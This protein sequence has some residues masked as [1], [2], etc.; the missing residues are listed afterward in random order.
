M[1][2][3]KN[4]ILIAI[5]IGFFVNAQTSTYRIEKEKINDLIHTK[6]D[7]SF[8]IPNSLLHGK[9]E[10]TL[11]PHFYNTD[12][13]TLDAK[14]M[15]IHSVKVNGIKTSYNYFENKELIIDL[16][17]SY[18][19]DEEF[20]VFIE[21]TAQPEKVIKMGL[22]DEKGLYFI[23]PTDDNP[24]IPTQIWSESEPDLASVWFPTIDSP[25]QKSTQ[26]IS[27]TVPS[28][29]VTLSN[30]NLVNQRE[31]SGGTR[32]DVW[33]QSLKHSPYLFFIGVG[34]FSIVK[35]IWNDK[36]VNYYVDKEQEP[37]AKGVFG[38]TPKMLQFFED[39]LGVQYP[40]DKYHQ[41]VVR[42][43]IS[44]AMEN[45]GAVVH[46]DQAY[47]DTRELID[48]NKWENT[49]AHEII[50]HWFGD[51]VTAESWSNL[52]L[53][54][55]FAN[56]GEYLWFEHEYG[57]DF[58][59]D[60]ISGERK[61]YLRSKQ[62]KSKDLIRFH[63]NKA[64][65]MF[66]SVTYEKGGLI[67]HMLRN[68]L[69]DE[70]FFEGLKKYLNDN[71]Y[72]TAEAHQLRIAL[73]K[74]SGK[75]L[76]WF[77]NQWFFGNGHPELLITYTIGAFENEVTINIGQT[78]NVFEF[79][80][81][82]DVY[83][84]TGKTTHTVWVNKKQESFSFSLDSKLKLI[85][86]N[87]NGTLLSEIAMNKSVQDAI[88]QYSHAKSYKSRKEAI[89]LLIENQ[90]DSRAFNSLTTALNDKSYKLRILI[91]EKLD[92]VNKYSKGKT[93]QKIEK[94]AKNDSHTLVQAAA[95]ITL[96]KL[97]DPKYK[98]HFLN[99][100]NSQSYKVIE[101]AIVGLY[102]LDKQLA[103][104]E[105][106][107][108]DDTVKSKMPK[109]LTGYYLENRVDKYMPF[110]A[111]NLIEGLFYVQDKKVADT[112]MKAF[113]WISQSDN[114]EAISNLVDSLVSNGIKYKKYGADIAALNF[115]RQMVNLQRATNNLNKK[116]LEIIIKKGM[117]EF[118]D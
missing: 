102:Q 92:L 99:A 118:I 16:G 106:D 93:I 69:G 18:S 22:A 61:S 40:W 50:H 84:E 2:L 1:I 9:A 78:N 79:P 42:E 85:D 91:L 21:Y 114:K 74:V 75:D 7:L 100:L 23:D 49:I 101:S 87:P 96:A 86:V 55:A 17:K 25:N 8:D 80:L 57:K 29:F 39:K 36:E 32:T 90:Q 71:K 60:F 10:I 30:G 65:D 45:T 38:K 44:G 109:V 70:V 34:E 26:E 53:N 103:L 63:Y 13:V 83:K 111:S 68:Y 20:K 81:E 117:A 62:N 35:D 58:A 89:E 59:D 33:K 28:K 47:Q 37:F 6:L 24:N 77:F 110:I 98:Q 54:E 56:Y 4:L 66:D 88:F 31:N 48:E 12:K 14:G 116:E 72:N 82:I 19:R 43:Y 52:P 105:I 67:L 94:I 115:L 112:Y 11:S 51:L 97:V 113:N 5:F 95:N 46:S 108:L 73:E 27:L 41:I 15:V 64:S 104:N 3:K 107:K 76:N